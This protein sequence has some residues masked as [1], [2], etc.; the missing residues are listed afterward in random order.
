M[1][2]WLAALALGCGVAWGQ[3]TPTPTATAI[4]TATLAP[5]PSPIPTPAPRPPSPPQAVRRASQGDEAARASDWRSALFAYQEAANLDPRNAELRLKLGGAY[6]KLGYLD[7]AIGQYRLAAALDPPGAEAQRRIDRV[8]AAQGGQPL[9]VEPVAPQPRPPGQAETPAA[10]AYEQGVALIA[11][12][13]YADALVSLDEAVRRDPRLPVAYTARASALFGLARYVEAAGD[14][15]TALALDPAQ[16]TP[17][18]GLGECY[19]QLGQIASALD[20]Y[21]RYVESGAADAREDLRSEAQRRLKE[22]AP[23]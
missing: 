5:A 1:R 11:G 6:E 15:R 14:Y 21:Q 2:P 10:A 19:R 22:L 7:E 3:A 4:P 17:L 18:F 16:A 8:R 9:P 13:A 12:G 23:K 20:H